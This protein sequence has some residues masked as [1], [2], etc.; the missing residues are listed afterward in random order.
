MV[1]E[2]HINSNNDGHMYIDKPVIIVIVVDVVGTSFVVIVL[3]YLVD[4][5]KLI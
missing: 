3:V 2:K 1:L 4:T 5:N